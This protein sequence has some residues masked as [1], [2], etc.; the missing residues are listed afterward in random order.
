MSRGIETGA[1]NDGDSGVFT[2]ENVTIAACV[3]VPLL[4]FALLACFC[5]VR[6]RNRGDNGD[7]SA[8]A[9]A[10]G[11]SAK[12]GGGGA[13][14]SGHA[15]AAAAAG[16]GAAAGHRAT[17]SGGKVYPDPRSPSPRNSLRVQEMNLAE[18]IV[19][20]ASAAGR[21]RD[22]TGAGEGKTKNPKKFARCESDTAFAMTSSED[23]TDDLIRGGGAHG[24]GS[25]SSGGAGTGRSSSPPGYEDDAAGSVFDSEGDLVENGW[26]VA[27]RENMTR[28][29]PP[30]YEATRRREQ[31][32]N[33]ERA[34]ARGAA[35]AGRHGIGR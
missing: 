32:T 1:A 31:Q 19:V 7:G 11:S 9:W 3:A 29:G 12:G 28:T 16:T 35:T 27:T 22:R 20:G 17:D 21:A 23:I 18:H 25:D 5:A 10:A 33:S 24:G 34:L 26:G 14:V 4:A 8:G 6:R 13:V 30:S 2:S 15:G